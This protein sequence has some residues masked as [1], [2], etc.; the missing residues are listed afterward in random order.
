M[1]HFRLG[2]CLE[3]TWEGWDRLVGVAEITPAPPSA[4]LLFRRT[5]V[6]RSRAT[7]VEKPEGA[8]V[9]CEEAVSGITASL[10]RS[11]YCDSKVW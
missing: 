4:R 11:R 3:P 10:R 1:G 8:N 2:G 9:C 6:R 7:P 5:W